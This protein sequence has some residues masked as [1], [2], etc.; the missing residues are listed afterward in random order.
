MEPT[1]H[2]TVDSATD[3]V[4]R[5]S[6]D[7][8]AQLE[9]KL[10]E[11]SM[12]RKEYARELDVTPAR[13]SQFLNDPGSFELSSM[14]NYAQALGMKVSVIAYDDGDSGNEN[15]PISSQVFNTC[16]TRCGSPHD[17]FQATTCTIG[18]AVSD[19]AA[20]ENNAMICVFGTG[21][22]PLPWMGT[23]NA[24]NATANAAHNV[25]NWQVGQNYSGCNTAPAVGNSYLFSPS[26]STWQ[27]VLSVKG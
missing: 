21:A 12:T 18:V 4:Y 3:F 6:S 19:I 25:I 7:F 16:W 26:A 23:G 20:T 10:E 5:I 15:G 24:I 14:V 13:V 27:D 9:T 8:V 22:L 1:S 17:M 11:K 2:W